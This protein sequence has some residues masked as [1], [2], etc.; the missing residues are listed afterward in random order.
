MSSAQLS[1]KAETYKAALC[2][3]S[4]TI[5]PRR[6]SVQQQQVEYELSVVASDP[7]TQG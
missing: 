6:V 7:A 4:S 3:K 5:S 2:H 1:D